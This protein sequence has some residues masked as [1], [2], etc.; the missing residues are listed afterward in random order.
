M[1]QQQT[2]KVCGRPDKF[3]FHVPNRIWAAVVPPKFRKLV[4]CLAC[5]DDFASVKGIDY[6]QG[7]EVLYF[8]GEQI[9]FEFR[10]VAAS[11]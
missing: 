3:D 9:A 6:S 11:R 5:F 2:C 1:M 8:A 4:V 7:I 10:P